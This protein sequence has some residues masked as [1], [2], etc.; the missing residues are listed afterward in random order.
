MRAR[1]IGAAARA[2]GPA[3]ALVLHFGARRCR[4]LTATLGQ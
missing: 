1:E 4:D 2:A 3:M